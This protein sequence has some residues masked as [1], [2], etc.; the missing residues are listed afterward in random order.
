M[1]EHRVV[2]A[3]EDD[4]DVQRIDIK[5]GSEIV[6]TIDHAQD[7]FEK[8]G[9]I[10][11][12]VDGLNPALRR[13][14]TRDMQKAYTGSGDAKSKKNE[15]DEVGA[16][17]LFGVVLP[18]YNLDYLAKL[19]ELSPPHASAVKAKVSNI[20]ALGF[21]FVESPQTREKIGSVAEGKRDGVRK[22]LSRHKSELY[23]WIDACNTEDE[24]IETLI[25]VWTDYETTGNGYLEVGR[26]NTGEIGYIGH[27][28]S[29]TVRIRKNRDGFVQMI[30]NK[31][32]FFRNFGDK[33][34]KDPIGNDQRPNE[35]VHLKK[36]SPTTGFYGVPD[37]I[38]AKQAIAG[39]EF[40]GRFNLDYFENKAVPRYVITI[41]GGN[42]S[43]SAERNLLEFFQTGL[44]GKNHRT[45]YVPLPAETPENKVDFKMEPVEAGTQDSSFVNYRKGNLSDILMSHR[46]PISKVGL[47]EGVS[48]AVA[49]DADKTFKEQVCR[50]EQRILEKKL[51][52][53]V[54]EK[55]DAFLLKLNELTLTDEDT[56][57]KMDERYLK[58]QVMV[59][60]DIRVRRWGWEGLPDGDKKV[61]LKPQQG[62]EMRAQGNRERDSRRSAGATDSAGEGRNEQ[63]AG[64][65]A[66]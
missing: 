37:I 38:S 42:L 21:D 66:D 36:Y 14:I 48:L 18:P 55:T 60:N 8:S 6:R 3:D 33:T 65:S 20:V 52:K 12:G 43:A 54:K 46:V 19:F 24:F 40:A 26:K 29:T 49:R 45:L 16:Y 47:A 53:L 2:P 57:S 28:P 34:T 25:K 32:V 30:S 58:M 63:G 59:P 15:F 7:P 22:K 50:P 13:K 61:D 9:D 35:L 39:N 64:R 51:N 17:N 5:I 10:L 27:V 23:E 4:D 11:K 41:K 56:L 62:A 44:K 31:A 1:T